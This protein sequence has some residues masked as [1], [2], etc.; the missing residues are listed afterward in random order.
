MRYL[1]ICMQNVKRVHLSIWWVTFWRGAKWFFISI[2]GNHTTFTIVWL[3]IYRY[4]FIYYT[5]IS[6]PCFCKKASGKWKIVLVKVSHRFY[7]VVEASSIIFSLSTHRYPD[8]GIIWKLFLPTTIGKSSKLLVAGTPS[9]Y[10]HPNKK[11]RS[12]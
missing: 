3:L 1:F 9:R 6:N 4:T 10:V 7:N 2:K 11:I 5:F 8:T 12:W